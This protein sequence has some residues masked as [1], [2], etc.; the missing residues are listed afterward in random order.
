MNAF[1]HIKEGNTESK[2]KNAIEEIVEGTNLIGNII[3]STLGPHGKMKMLVSENNLKITNDGA[4]IMK[5]LVCSSPSARVL[6]NLSKSQDWEEGDG[7]TTVVV[8]ASSLINEG[9]KLNIPKISVLRG[10]ELGLKRCLE[11][12]DSQKFIGKEADLINL[13]KTTLCSKVVKSHLNKFAKICVEAVNRVDDLEMINIIKI[14]GRVEDS[15]LEDGFLLDKE[16]Y[17]PTLKN[18]KILVANTSLDTD[19]VKI[20]GAKVQVESIDELS[21]IEIAERKKMNDKVKMICSNNIDLFIN[22]QL[23]YDYPLQLFKNFGVVPIENADFE[24]VERLSN[25]LGAKI[26][27]HFNKIGDKTCDLE[28]QN[29]NNKRKFT[30]LSEDVY[31]TCDEVSNF[32]VDDRVLIRF[33]G[34]KRGA[35]T[36]VLRGA[37]EEFLEEA[38]RSIH[39]A[40]CVLHQHADLIYG[41]GSIEAEMAVQLQALSSKTESRESAAISAFSHALMQIPAVLAE[42]AGL[43]VEDVKS[44]LRAFH[45]KGKKTFGVGNNVECMKQKGV[46][47]SLRIKKRILTSAVEA[48]QMILKCDSIV[49]A[50]PRERTRE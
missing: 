17:I 49:K 27:S 33:K 10:Y 29:D 6:M 34:S 39:D 32:I 43:D 9:A 23:I 16:I 18:P 2:G 4:T 40:L 28:S 24:G 47:E 20:Y 26:M 37:S 14:P 22:R 7:T 25:F 15:F 13:A 48:A 1:S 12:L 36:I 31:G 45:V 21:E 38:E 8:L 50:K 11:V 42:N 35:V 19:K 30:N 41:G 46:V 5:N 3:K 44:K